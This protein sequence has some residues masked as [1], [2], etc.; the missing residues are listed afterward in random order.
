LAISQ[1][2]L[3]TANAFHLPL[4]EIPS[5]ALPLGFYGDLS[6]ASN[7]YGFFSPGVYAQIRAIVEVEDKNGNKTTR[8]LLDNTNRETD[9]RVNDAFEHF[10]NEFDDKVKFQRI[11]AASLAGSVF[12]RHADAEKVGIRIERLTA[13]SRKAYLAGHKT[14]TWDQLYSV[15]F[16]NRPTARAK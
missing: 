11:L 13:P 4:S 12:A 1:I 7:G 15:E 5:L 10:I 14:G 6:G 8:P 16:V 3:V 2:A 9:L